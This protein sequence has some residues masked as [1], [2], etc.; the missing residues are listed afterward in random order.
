[1]DT[2]GENTVTGMT[3]ES[4]STKIDTTSVNSG[5]SS[6]HLLFANLVKNRGG[7]IQPQETNISKFSCDRCAAHMRR[8]LT[9]LRA[10]SASSMSAR[11]Q[12]DK[13]NHHPSCP[14]YKSQMFTKSSIRKQYALEESKPPARA[15]GSPTPVSLANNRMTSDNKTSSILRHINPHTLSSFSKHRIAMHDNTDEILESR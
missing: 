8:S 2:S 4:E 10:S 12:D 14:N 13:Y 5:L 1:M 11:G 3:T 15:Q 6:Q 9:D 7:Y